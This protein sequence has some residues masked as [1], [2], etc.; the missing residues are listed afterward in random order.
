MNIRILI[1]GMPRAGSTWLYN[2]VRYSYINSGFRTYADYNDRYNPAVDAD[3]HVVKIHPFNESLLL[4]SQVVLTPC[5][6]LRDVLASLVRRNL[7]K[8]EPDALAA[9]A[10]RILDREYLPWVQ[11]S[12]CE[13]RYETMVI[14]KPKAIAQ[15]LALLNL[16]DVDP[17]EVHRDVEKLRKVVVAERDRT[18]QLWPDHFTDGRANSFFT[19]L[20]EESVLAIEKVASPWLR[21]KGYELCYPPS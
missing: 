8:N 12:T 10:R 17:E 21:A 9:R 16:L 15:I 7:V 3:V 14:D 13:I 11:H 6:D 20:S 19:T 1:A 4:S 2:A 5:R 18:T